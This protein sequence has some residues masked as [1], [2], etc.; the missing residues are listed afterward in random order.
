MRRL[1][2]Q[3]STGMLRGDPAYFRQLECALQ[4]HQTGEKAKKESMRGFF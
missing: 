1:K 3:G 4:F 2:V